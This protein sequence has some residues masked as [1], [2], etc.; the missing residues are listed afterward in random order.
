M[1]A[2][3]GSKDYQIAQVTTGLIIPEY[4]FTSGEI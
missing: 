2:T 3:D 4:Q 1:Y